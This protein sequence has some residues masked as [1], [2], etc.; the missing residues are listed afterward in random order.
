MRIQD[1]ADILIMTLLVYQLYNWFRRTRALQVVMGLGFLV[2]LY[3]ITKNF[4]LFMTSWILQELGTVIF[5]LI[6]VVFQGEIRQALYR[7]S[8]M[9]N[10]FDRGGDAGP[11]NMTELATTVFALAERRTG[12]LIVFARQE[13]LDDLLLHGVRLD[14]LISG[15]LLASIFEE[16]LPLHDGAVIITNG[17]ISEAST[18]L[19]L[20]S[21]GDLPQHLGTRHRAALGLTERSDAVVVVVSEERG[22]VSLAHAGEL[23]RVS[24]PEML[25]TMLQQYLETAKPKVDRVSLR[26]RLFSNFVPKMVTFLLVFVSWL[27]LTAREGGLQTVNAQVKFHNLPENLVLKAG[28]PEEVEVQLK[29]LSSLFTSSKKLEVAADLDLSK[30]REGTNNLQVDS[31]AFQLPLG[32]SVIRVNPAT[33]RV[34]AEKKGYRELPLHLNRSGRLPQGV[35]LRSTRLEPSRV[36]VEGP[37]SE[38]ARLWHVETE[39]LDLSSIRK[40]QTVELKVLQP[41]PQVHIRLDDPVK[42]RVVAGSR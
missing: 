19:P 31:K 36:T 2:I 34:V 15:Q 6:I 10:F 37:E 3:I 22:E 14:S 39:P 17:R 29:V 21:S 25:V 24:T 26:Q 1:V 5:V 41:S 9:R 18:H 40:S 42:V 7:F 20:S 12:A 13:K 23:V 11:F 32:V 30:I 4:G 28:A 33:L 8:L 16:G 35:W 27:I 38:L